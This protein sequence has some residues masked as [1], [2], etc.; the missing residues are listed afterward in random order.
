M[1]I[2]SDNA[3]RFLKLASTRGCTGVNHG[4]ICDSRPS[5][6]SGYPRGHRVNTEAQCHR[7]VTPTGDKD[8]HPRTRAS[9]EP[10][11]H[12]QKRSPE[13]EGSSRETLKRLVISVCQRR[14]FLPS[15]IELA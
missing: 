1:F 13:M 5:A 7:H 8:A 15:S 12:H 3:D 6:F 14:S 4:S 2:S 11:G 10:T 9:P